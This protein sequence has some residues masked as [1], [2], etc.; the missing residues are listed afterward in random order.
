MILLNHDLVLNFAVVVY[1]KAGGGRKKHSRGTKLPQ[2]CPIQ[3]RPT[4]AT[5]SYL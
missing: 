1:D 2:G 3:T 4:F 5:D